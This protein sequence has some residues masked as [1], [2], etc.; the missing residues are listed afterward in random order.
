LNC[1]RDQ[2]VS[3]EGRMRIAVDVDRA[4][5]DTRFDATVGD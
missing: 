3:A 2:R 1:W 5:A 4:A